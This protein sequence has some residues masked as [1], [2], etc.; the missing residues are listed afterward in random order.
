MGLRVT[1]C[2]SKFSSVEGVLVG[3]GKVC[4]AWE[5]GLPLSSQVHRSF[6]DEVWRPPRYLYSRIGVSSCS[7][8]LYFSDA[9]L[10]VDVCVESDKPVL[11]LRS[12]DAVSMAGVSIAGSTIAYSRSSAGAIESLDSQAALGK[13]M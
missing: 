6:C 11:S 13:D 10:L 1:R 3:R 9:L 7:S 12:S 5:R 8:S 2:F 4:E